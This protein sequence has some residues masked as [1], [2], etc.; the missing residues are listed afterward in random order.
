MQDLAMSFPKPTVDLAH[1]RRK[2]H[3]AALEEKKA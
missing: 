1:M 2:Y 3:A